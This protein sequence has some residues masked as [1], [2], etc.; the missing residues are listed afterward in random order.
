MGERKRPVVRLAQHRQLQQVAVPP[1]AHQEPVAARNVAAASWDLQALLGSREP[2]DRQAKTATR[3]RT[4]NRVKM[5]LRPPQQRLASANA[6]QDR[7]VRRAVPAT[8]D[9]KVTRASRESP[10]PPG[11]RARG[12]HPASKDL[13]D[14]PD[15]LAVPETGVNPES[16]CPEWR[17]PAHREGPE[18]WDRPGSQD[19]Q[20]RRASPERLD[21]RERRATKETR[22]R[23]ANLASPALKARPV[24]TEPSVLATIVPSRGRHPATEDDDEKLS[25]PKDWLMGGD[26]PP[27]ASPP[28]LSVC[29]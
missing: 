10:V 22:A 13:P 2:M 5:R 19:R 16:M 11:N 8:K 14:H 3:A 25:L 17:R 7:L 27:M 12:G 15:C 21:P 23:T 20:E 4:D 29:L 28:F 26:Q 18:R 1:A 24:R 9:P 6:R